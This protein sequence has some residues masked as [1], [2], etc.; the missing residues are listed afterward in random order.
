LVV[1]SHSIG[2]QVF[3]QIVLAPI[4]DVI[5]VDL[6]GPGEAEAGA[7]SVKRWSDDPEAFGLTTVLA[8]G[9]TRR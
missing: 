4:A 8:V 3:A 5:D 6:L 1:N 2:R 7:I 9:G